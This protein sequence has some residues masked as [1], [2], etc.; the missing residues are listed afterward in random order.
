VAA[1]LVP[2]A[3]S[4]DAG[5]SI[6]LP[7]SACGLVG[8][9]PS[10][11]RVSLTPDFGDLASGAVAEFVITRSVRDA[12]GVLEAITTT[13]VGGEPY[14]A[15]HHDGSYLDACRSPG[16]L[17]VGLMDTAPAGRVLVHSDCTSAVE[18][19]GRLLR[20]WA[21]MWNR[22]IR[23]RLTTMASPATP[24][25]SFPSVIAHLLSSGGNGA[26]VSGW[27]QTTWSHGRGPAPAGPGHQ[28]RPV[29]LRSGMDPSLESPN[30]HL[31]R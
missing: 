17:R 3:H 20:A 16:A 31:V 4:N 7:A 14:L 11:G 28:R 23:P 13:P 12:A 1:G 19:A 18:A 27:A 9:K 5:G 26:P 21:T 22:V 24:P 25:T 10:R 29:P 2:V 8:L 15:P 30:G 6:R